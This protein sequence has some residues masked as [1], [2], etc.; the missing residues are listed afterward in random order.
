MAIDLIEGKDH[1]FIADKRLLENK[2][3]IDTY[4]RNNWEYNDLRTPKILNFDSLFS[5]SILWKNKSVGYINEKWNS[6]SVLDFTIL[7]KDFKMNKSVSLVNSKTIIIS[8]QKNIFHIN[9]F[10][11]TSY[12]IYDLRESGAYIYD[13]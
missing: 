13:F 6:N 11:K 10:S 7:G 3:L 12:P 4:I 2:K 1:F 5:K 8:N 9:G